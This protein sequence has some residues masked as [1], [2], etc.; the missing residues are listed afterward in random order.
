MTDNIIDFKEITERALLFFPYDTKTKNG[1]ARSEEFKDLCRSAGLFVAGEDRQIPR[2]ISPF[3][4]IGAGKL[5]SA[6]KE[7]E[8]AEANVFVFDGELS[9]AQTRNICEG[10]GGIKVI[11]REQLIL[12]IFAQRAVTAEGKLQVELAQ[13]SY[14][15][16]RLKGLGTALS[17]LGGGIGTRGPGETQLETDRRHIR[18]RILSLKN[19]L[20]EVSSRREAQRKRREKNETFVVALC[21]Y[22]NTG[23]STLLNA[24]TGSETLAEDKLFATLDPTAR[25]FSSDG[26]PAVMIDTVGF[27]RDI[28]TDLIDAFKT[29]LESVRE[30][31]LVLLVSDASGDHETEIAE[32]MKILNDLSVNAPIVKVFNKCDKISDFSDFSN[33][34]VFISALHGK[35]LDR[36][37]TRIVS[38]M[39]TFYSRMRFFV[40]YT[41][42]QSFF[43]LRKYC[44]TLKV[45]YNENG[46]V[47]DA[48]IPKYYLSLF[49]SFQIRQPEA[50][51]FR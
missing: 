10:L 45:T 41:K 26:F 11:D 25:K 50:T 31:D 2:E 37:K 27:I 35:G 1:A 7:A 47:F 39:E 42:T 15:Y 13:L 32:S 44:A 29:T 33:D 34:S 20:E 5:E 18:A 12:D 28:P 38:Y 9:P 48:V 21:G 3:T 8:E 51:S 22:T 19:Q 43:R 24:I 4:Y 16:P 36:L 23:K 49:S 30:A 46:A 17:R 14:L 6:R 40:P